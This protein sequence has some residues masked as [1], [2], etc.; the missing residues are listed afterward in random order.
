MNALDIL[1]NDHRRILQLLQQVESTLSTDARAES[2]ADLVRAIHQHQRALQEVLYPALE[3]RNEPKAFI[4][5]QAQ[6]DMR[7]QQILARISE[8]NQS[9][10]MRTQLTDLRKAIAG[11]IGFAESRI[12]PEAERLLGQGRLLELSYEVEQIRTK[13][14]EQ[15]S[16]IYPARRMGPEPN[17]HS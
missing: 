16:A 11:H 15:D 4:H 14:S 13:Q 8:T 3:E 2:V 7:I 5:I 17:P 10:E 1:K 9:P 6:N 12:F